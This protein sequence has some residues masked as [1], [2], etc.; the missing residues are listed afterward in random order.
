ME[1]KS[2]DIEEIEY[3]IA[4]IEDS[5]QIEFEENELQNVKTYGELCDEIKKKIELQSIDNCTSQQAFY[6]LRNIIIKLTNS[7]KIEVSPKTEL[8]NLFPEKNRALKVQ[9]IEKEL[10]F[11]LSILRPTK[12]VI[13]IVSLFMLVS[14]IGIFFSW[15][16][17]FLG[18]GMSIFGFWI[19]QKTGNTFTL[20]T[21]GNLADKMVRDNYL[22]SRRNPK[23]VNRKEIENVISDLFSD[24]LYLDKSKLT[25]EAELY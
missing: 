21:V 17:G 25:R 23:T 11:E 12:L 22:K 4:K 3:L 9:A 24:Y 5:F 8:I 1:L 20:K 15:K 14:F 13:G 16:F 18:I 7:E 10:G 6:K 2:I 19:A